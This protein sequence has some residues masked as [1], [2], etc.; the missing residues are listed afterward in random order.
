M[1]CSQER[2]PR[3]VSSHTLVVENAEST[4]TG[5]H[6]ITSEHASTTEA[7]PRTHKDASG[8]VYRIDPP[9]S[10]STML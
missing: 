10:T 7:K 4:L 5:V 3:A 2:T 1:V 9:D 6:I 8:P